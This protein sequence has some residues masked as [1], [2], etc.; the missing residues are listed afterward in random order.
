[1]AKAKASPGISL[2]D[3][4]ISQEIINK[5]TPAE[6][7]ATIANLAKL[8]DQR[9]RKTRN[10]NNVGFRALSPQFTNEETGKSGTGGVVVSTPFGSQHLFSGIL[11][12]IMQASRDDK[13]YEAMCQWLVTNGRAKHVMGGKKT[14][15]LEAF[16]LD[17]ILGKVP[18][19]PKLTF[20]DEGQSAPG[21]G[22]N[23]D[24]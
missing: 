13:A 19:V 23:R 20:V 14:P 7:T 10:P 16:T 21:A 15:L 2:A 1:M 5:M 6:V 22:S 24:E 18:V 11:L 8:G 4:G 9:A 12:A 3:Y 17:Q